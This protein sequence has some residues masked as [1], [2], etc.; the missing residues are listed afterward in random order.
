VQSLDD[1]QRLR[2]Q[3]KLTNA[4]AE[5]VKCASEACPVVVREDCAR[6]LIEVDGAIPTIVLSATGDSGEDVTDARVYIDGAFTLDK[7]D[8]RARA[9]DPGTHTFKFERSGREPVS[10]TLLILE[11]E[12]NRQVV[13]KFKSDAP[14]PPSASASSAPPPSASVFTP[15]PPAS[16]A[17]PAEHA[18]IPIIPIV[19]A[20]VGAAALG[21]ALYFR[22]RADADADNLRGSCA[23]A[24]DPSER[25]ALSN[26]LVVANV[27]FGIGL[28]ALA[29]AAVTW[30]LTS[31][32]K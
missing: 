22:L 4:R 21:S 17:V 8:G 28:G 9:L 25:D 5:L 16:S 27:S 19:L 3:K 26:K 18:P 31:K 13:A 1:A 24:C 23:P 15:P 30:V 29:A 10:L 6:S 12:K 2:S 11:G 20:G 7:L 14:P 32:W